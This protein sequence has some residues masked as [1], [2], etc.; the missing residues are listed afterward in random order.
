LFQYVSAATEDRLGLKT[1]AWTGVNNFFMQSG[2]DFI[3][4]GGG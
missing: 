1:Y 4:V 2:G 3:A